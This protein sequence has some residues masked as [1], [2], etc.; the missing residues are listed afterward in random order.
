[1]SNTHSTPSV[2]LHRALWGVQVLVG[3]AFLAAGSWK[4][5]TPLPDLEKALP[6]VASTPSALVR[7]IGVSELL[8]GLGLILPSGLRIL[9]KLTPLAAALLAV[10]M[11][12]A[13][14]MH[15]SRGELGALP[16]NFV[17]GGLALFVAWG[18]T[19]AAPIAAK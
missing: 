18:R 19:K 17:L 4:A 16:V 3:L 15:A 2:G 13:A 10:V 12:L 9:P 14:A 5:T 7:F 8:G 11:V 1:M 6:W